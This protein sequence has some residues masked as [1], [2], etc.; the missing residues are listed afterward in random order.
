MVLVL[1]DGTRW[2]IEPHLH[3]S[4]KLM[5]TVDLDQ[6]VRFECIFQSSI[7]L[8]QE[9]QNNLAEINRELVPADEKSL[10]T[11][12]ECFSNLVK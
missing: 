12:D 4:K 7:K 5:A 8:D 11:V 2:K 10:R 6:V 9:R 3:S 1:K